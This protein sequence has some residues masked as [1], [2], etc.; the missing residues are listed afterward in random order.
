MADSNRLHS[1]NTS[2]VLRAIRQNPGISR[3]K[4]AELLDLDRSTVTKIMQVILDRGLVCTAGKN[5]E[6]SGVGRRQI[7]L[8]INQE[9]GVVLGMEIQETC[10]QAVLIDLSGTILQV[11]S[12]EYAISPETLDTTLTEIIRGARAAAT[13]T[14]RF[15]LGVGIGIP[16]IIDPYSGSIRNSYP[17][18]VESPYPL[19]ERLALLCP[20][21]VFIENDA[22]CCCWS[23]LAFRPGEENRNFIAVL[24]EFRKNVFPSKGTGLACGLGFVIRSRVLHGDHFTA[25]EFRSIYSSR[26]DPQFRANRKDLSSLPENTTLLRQIYRELCDNLGF[27][28][29]CVD[30]N[31]IVFAGDLPA[32][33]ENLEKAMADSLAKNCACGPN[34]PVN[35]EFSPYGEKAVCVGA[36]GMFIEK[37]FTVPDVADHFKETVG[38]DLFERIL[39]GRK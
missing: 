27:L 30:L 17:F 37:L 20:E 6:Q 21:P 14:G 7:N 15:L 16:G 4:V 36:A 33:R 35:V 25:G 26:T 5:T 32:Y 19:R 28:A 31:K 24:G 10:Y 23:E 22:N 39:K 38:Y 8:E 2:R 18:C 13:A 29:N 34:R 12:G 3:I 1:V 9:I 11:F